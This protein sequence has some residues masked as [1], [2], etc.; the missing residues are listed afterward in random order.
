MLVKRTFSTS[1]KK[2]YFLDIP[3]N[4]LEKTIILKDFEYSEEP[5][6]Y[7]LEKMKED[8]CSAQIE[9]SGRISRDCKNKKIYVQLDKMRITYKDVKRRYFSEIHTKA[10]IAQE[11]YE[12]QRN[13]SENLRKTAKREEYPKPLVANSEASQSAFENLVKLSPKRS[14]LVAESAMFKKPRSQ[15]PLSKRTNTCSK[16]MKK[17]WKESLKEANS[18]SYVSKSLIK[19]SEKIPERVKEPTKRSKGNINSG[20]EEL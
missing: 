11:N 3:R 13:K 15:V 20:S 10:S 19:P 14:T 9:K 18:Y 17:T 16:L 7:F 12:W 6:I 8:I 2:K 4:R 1:D 5:K